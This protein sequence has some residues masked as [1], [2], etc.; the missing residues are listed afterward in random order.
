M[1]SPSER[2]VPAFCSVAGIQRF[3]A[4]AAL[5]LIVAGAPARADSALDP[6][7]APASA[8]SEEPDSEASAPQH[9]RLPFLA[10]E[11]RKRGIELP[12]TYGVGLVYYHLDRAIDISDVRVGR[13]GADPSS[14]SDFAQLDSDSR[15]DN[16]NLKFDV[17]IL[18]FLN[19][20]A[21]AGYIWNESTTNIEATLPP[22]APGG[23]PRQF[24]F[25]VPTEMTGTVGGLGMTLAGGYRSLFF[26]ADLNVAKADLGFDDNFRAV[27]TSVRTGWNGR[28][29]SRPMQ[30]WL[31][32]TYWNTY[33]EATGTV[34]DPDGGRLSFEV[35]QGPAH[36]YTYGLGLSYTIR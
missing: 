1:S 24:T 13:N 15:V 6:P 9:H 29:G 33:A 18:P 25:S 28:A 16:L 4:A 32:A 30:V 19:L 3:S 12:R 10:E 26:S 22:I 31:N 8:S 35:D 2:S 27:V 14:V 17:W 23:S 20:Y 36:P 21:I 7:A 5:V 11:A 34:D